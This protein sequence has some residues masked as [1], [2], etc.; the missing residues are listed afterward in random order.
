MKKISFSILAVALAAPLFTSCI[1][2]Y[3]PMDGSLTEQMAMEAPGY[4][5]SAAQ[6]IT[7]NLVGQWSYY[8]SKPKDGA[9][10]D[11][12]YA[13]FF[14]ERDVMGQDMVPQGT[15][16]WFATWY[17][18]NPALGCQYQRC[19]V[20]WTIYWKW[21]DACNKLLVI[22]KNNPEEDFR[23]G[24]GIAYAMRAMFYQDV[25]RMYA[26]KP[27]SLDPEAETVPLVLDDTGITYSNPRMTVKAAYT[28]IL[29][30]LD[31]AEELLDGYVRPDVTTP[32]LSVVYGLKARAY[33][34]IQDWE[35]AEKYA[36]M[37]QEGYT[38]MSKEEYLSRDNGFNKP[39]S[40][41]MFGMQYHLTDPSIKDDDGDSSWGSW[42]IMENG[43]KCGYAANYGGPTVID[44]H[45]YET[46]PATDFRKQLFVDFAI[47][48]MSKG[49]A[50]EALS[51][52]TDYPDQI[53][54]SAGSAEY[55]PGGFQ[56]KFRPQAGKYMTKYEAWVV[57]IPLMRVEEMMLIEAE[58]A[59]MQ[60]E[61]RGIELLTKFA[62]T[63]DANYV[64]GTHQ[65]AY[66]NAATSKFQNEVWWQ[67][68]VELWGEGF[69][70][71]DIKRLNKAIIRNYENTNHIEG[72]RWNFVNQSGGRNYPD[73]MNLSI[74]NTEVLYNTACTNN[75]D[76]VAPTGDTE[77]L[78]AW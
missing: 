26:A 24:A 8:G 37:A 32:D 50:I 42:M 74:V 66:G 11:F 63:R 15:N 28:Q 12:G 5:Q 78:F 9:A 10:Y 58:A 70:T 43:F 45:L 62:K 3:D 73:W 67:R 44:R 46:I 49:K 51:A 33:L 59:G 56:F 53:L 6:A 54:A 36:K 23:T 4:F 21:I 22:Y 13:S 52:Y 40:S 61:S 18:C 77:E 7:S 71:F 25:V 57:A 20:P 30:D 64:Y 35:N 14:L 76:P 17:E 16:N 2:Q 69:S 29:E 60:Q 72:N 48:G 19:Q 31:K 39:T 65:D 68:R 41:W 47:D 34:E 75:P 55:G 38:M 1:E 27:Y